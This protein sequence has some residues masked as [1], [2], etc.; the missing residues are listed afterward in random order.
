M[1]ENKLS[2]GR[3]TEVF[4]ELKHLRLATCKVSQTLNKIIGYIEDVLSGKCSGDP[5][6]GRLL[7]DML[8]KVPDVPPSQFEHLLNNSMQVCAYHSSSFLWTIDTCTSS[9]IGSPDSLV[10]IKFDKNTTCNG[11]KTVFVDVLKFVGFSIILFLV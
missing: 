3:Q 6:V 5:E 2:D 4:T 9:I 8:S 1:Q 7:M 10:S 11:R